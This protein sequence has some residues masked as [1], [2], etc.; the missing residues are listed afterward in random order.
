MDKG[1][2][3]PTSSQKG[4]LQSTDQIIEDKIKRKAERDGGSGNRKGI[5]EEK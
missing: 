2:K 1:V 4:P 5:R 3:N